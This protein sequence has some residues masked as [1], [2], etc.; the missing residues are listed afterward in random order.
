MRF[1]VNRFQSGLII[2]CTRKKNTWPS[3]PQVFKEETSWFWELILL[4]N[5][6]YFTCLFVSLY[7]FIADKNRTIHG[8]L[9]SR[10]IRPRCYGRSILAGNLK[11]CDMTYIPMSYEKV[12]GN[13]FFDVCFLAYRGVP[14]H[15]WCC[16][17]GNKTLAVRFPAVSQT[18]WP[19]LAPHKFWHF[20]PEVNNMAYFW[21]LMTG[22]I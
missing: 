3:V 19:N 10:V 2:K 13:E 16:T 7:R 5:T 4:H 6:N 17:E 11:L 15:H 14:L 18:I 21:H 8:C 22:L 1:V 20:L 12:R 9:Y